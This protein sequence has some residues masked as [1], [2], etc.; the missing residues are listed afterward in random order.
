MTPPVPAVGFVV[1]EILVTAGFGISTTAPVLSR[2]DL[3][4]RRLSCW[5]KAAATRS[6][7]MASIAAGSNTGGA[8]P[9]LF[10]RVLRLGGIAVTEE[11]A[12]PQRYGGGTSWEGHVRGGDVLEDGESGVCAIRVKTKA[13]SKLPSANKLPPISTLKQPFYGM[14][15]TSVK[16]FE[17]TPVH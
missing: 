6:A 13:L 14:E 11:W 16:N 7:I 5:A 17:A 4:V 15:H 8:S 2:S 9:P 1:H 12:I 3:S 10:E